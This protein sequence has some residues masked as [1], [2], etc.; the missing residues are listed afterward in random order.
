MSGVKQDLLQTSDPLLFFAASSPRELKNQVENLLQKS[1]LDESDVWQHHN[2][3]DDQGTCRLFVQATS[4]D[5]LSQALSQ[6]KAR[7]D[8]GIRRDGKVAKGIFYVENT[9]VY[10][11]KI[12]FVFPGQ[13]SQFPGMG[14]E[15]AKR[16]P[17]IERWITWLDDALSDTLGEKPS[18]YFY[19]GKYA[20]DTHPKLFDLDIGA[21]IV[22]TLS[23][24]YYDLINQLNLKPDIFLGHS[25]GEFTALM[26][27]DYMQGAVQADTFKAIQKEFVQAYRATSEK[28]EPPEGT[29]YSVGALNTEGILPCL[30]EPVQEAFIALD[31]CPNQ[32][33]VFCHDHDASTLSSRLKNA[34]AILD[35]M[36]FRYAYHTPLFS[37]MSQEIVRFCEQFQFGQG[38]GTLYSCVTTK[39]FPVEASEA[40][41]QLGRLLYG[42]VRFH[43]TIEKLY[44]QG[45]RVFI[46][47]GPR[48]NISSFMQDTLRGK[49]ALV[50]STGQASTGETDAFLQMLGQLFTVGK[51][52]HVQ[53]LYPTQKATQRE[54]VPV[55][56]VATNK[57]LDNTTHA[58]L[59]ST[60]FALMQD[61]LQQQVRIMEQVKQYSKTTLT[62]QQPSQKTWSLLGKLIEQDKK[63]A[64][65]SREVTVDQEPYLLHHAFGGQPSLFAPELSALPVIPFTF[66]MEA[67]AESALALA[68]QG[69]V[70]QR[71]FDVRALSW[72]VLIEQ[73]VNLEIQAQ[74]LDKQHI[75]CRIFNTTHGQKRLSFESKIELAWQKNPMPQYLNIV[76]SGHI[77][78]PYHK[79]N[80]YI[81][82]H[83]VKPW[84]PGEFHGNSFQAVKKIVHMGDDGVVAELEVLPKHQLLK[85]IETPHFVID[86][87]IIDASM[88][89]TT[90]WAHSKYGVDLTILPFQIS[91]L[92][93]FLPPIAKGSKV[94]VN[95]RIQYV[96]TN[97]EPLPQDASY[98]FFDAQ[99]RL[100]AE[101]LLLDKDVK[102]S[103]KA[104]AYHRLYP[105]TVAI[106]SDIEYL[107]E[108]G[109]LL[110]T[111]QGRLDMHFSVP[112]RY[113]K[114]TNY[115]A[116][117][118]LS[119]RLD[120]I[121]TF[122][123]FSKDFLFSSGKVWLYKLAY[124]IFTQDERLYWLSID[125]DLDYLYQ[126]IVCKDAMRGRLK[127]M[128][129]QHY[130][131]V[132]L[133]CEKQQN[134]LWECRVVH[135][136]TSIRAECINVQREGEEYIACFLG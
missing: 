20:T 1:V 101:H 82:K 77:P 63:K 9:E 24:A 16:Y 125:E 25:T 47:I 61:F 2:K 135:G 111:L 118:L 69:W 18:T 133:A 132:D 57:P 36:P 71:I 50:V 64:R 103:P 26:A 117:Y 85:G 58:Q 56:P 74:Y 34:G 38:E 10:Q 3:L 62:H 31:N 107:D 8:R 136:D 114:F 112:T 104:V 15:L 45:V 78:T 105:E 92:Q 80:F 94:I 19:Q 35:E 27:S 41:K 59:L 96:Q 48:N 126:V 106:Q 100:I 97:G 83:P 68:G 128:A 95:V 60:H 4:F 33:I 49:L 12:A 42:Q 55:Q 29:L 21:C 123:P 14:S 115:P 54:E 81:G 121:Y 13:G 79:G 5:N 22:S 124:L 11:G 32:K 40:R 88:H 87:I 30:Q 28:T 109:Q 52:Q 39:P 108:H 90:Y 129:K 86:P 130:S 102:S 116:Y 70:I 119:E 7:L 67:T 120:D 51:L 122:K 6:A 134:G 110:A 89:I 66:S 99:D 98:Q 53:H 93:Y 65:W 75:L 37:E 73:S 127:S 76:P 72:F 44:T 84:V 91:S 23:L 131:P 43:D 17:K 46:E 113:N